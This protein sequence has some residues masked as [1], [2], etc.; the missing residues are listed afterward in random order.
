MRIVLPL[1]LVVGLSACN[2]TPIPDSGAEATGVGFGNRVAYQTEREQREA[3]LSGQSVVGLDGAV[4]G[5]VAGAPLSALSADPGTP[6]AVASTGDIAAD[7]RAALGVTQ[8][9]V[10]DAPRLSD[11]QNF[12]AVAN[13]ETIES[14]RQ[15]LEQ[16]RQQF[17]A[18][19][20]TAVPE[21]PE[22]GLGPNIV[23][24]ALSTT[25]PRGQAV[26]RR[27][28]LFGTRDGRNC[29]RYSNANEAQEVFLEAGGP[30]QDRQGLD[31]DGDGYACG[32]DPRPFRLA[33][34]GN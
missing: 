18:V 22:G 32:W 29:N 1:V 27:T 26:Y 6:T 3:A 20:P 31:P 17:E 13:R 9:P 5:E 2:S 25:H 24:F 23:Q 14:D 7:T 8:A 34:S 16:Q 10:S 30:E 21:R 12:D 4:S 33:A 19:A 15:R 28:N 11:E